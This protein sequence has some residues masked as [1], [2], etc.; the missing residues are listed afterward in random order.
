MNKDIIRLGAAAAVLA[1]AASASADPL[2]LASTEAR[3]A[4]LNPVIPRHVSEF[5]GDFS[6]FL[7]VNW[8]D[9]TPPIVEASR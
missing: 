2:Q 1:V 7:K 4:V 8:A 5:G 3:V 6:L 9:A